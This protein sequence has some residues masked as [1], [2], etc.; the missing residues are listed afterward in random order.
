[1]I[2]NDALCEACCRQHGR[3]FETCNSGCH[4]RDL[5]ECKEIPC[6]KP[7]DGHTSKDVRRLLSLPTVE[8]KRVRCSSCRKVYVQP[9][10]GAHHCPFCAK[11]DKWIEWDGEDDEYYPPETVTNMRGEEDG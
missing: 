1:M 7:W 11:W 2:Q 10:A 9:V 3:I 4:I 6:G 5:F 8:P